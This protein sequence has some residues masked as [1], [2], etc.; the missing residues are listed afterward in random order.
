M[1]PKLLMQYLPQLF[2]LMP[3]VT[4]VVPMADKYLQAR[5]ANESAVVT[6]LEGV[7]SDL[8]TTSAGLQT[9][10]AQVRKA[11]LEMAERLDEFAGRVELGVTEATRGRMA[12]EL[13]Q[14]HAAEVETQLRSLRLW[15]KVGVVLILVLLLVVISLMLKEHQVA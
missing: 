8:G 12:A 15:V 2:E 5:S 10:L 13:A 11:H 6:T 7:R 9:E 1:W 3:H 14:N 4:R